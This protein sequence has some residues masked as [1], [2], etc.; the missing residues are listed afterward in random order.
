MSDES[1]SDSDGTSPRSVT[2]D[3]RQYLQLLTTGAV[4]GAVAVGIDTLVGDDGQ[5]SRPV[6]ITGNG[7][8]AYDVVV[9]EQGEVYEALDPTGDTLVSGSDGW[10]V[11]D[12][13]IDSVPE[14]G[15]IFVSGQYDGTSTIEIGKSIQMVGQQA[16]IDHRQLGD[17]VF[18][19]EGEELQRTTLAEATEHGD[20]TVTLEET[21]GIRK[22]DMV[23]LEEVDGDPVLGRDH[24]PGEPHSVLEVQDGTVGLEDTIVWRDGYPSGTLV[25]VV[26]PIEVHVSGFTMTA[27][28]KDE[29]YVGVTAHQCRDSSFSNLKIDKFGARGIMLEACANCRVRDCTVL[30]SADID[31]ADGYGVQIWAGCHDI[32]V[33]GCVAKECRHPLSVTA[34]GDR[35]VASRSITF[36]DCFVTANGSSALNCH[37]G[38]AHDVRFEGCVVHTWDDSGVSTGA[39]KTLVSDCEFRTN[40][41]NAIDTRDDGQEMILAVTDTDIFGAFSAVH[42]GREEKYTFEPLWEVVHLD[43]VR[44][45]GCNRYF[46]LDPGAVDRV[47]NLVI[48]SCYWDEVEEGGLRIENSIDGGVIEGN[49]FGGTRS[50]SH[51]R[52]YDDADVDV[53]DLQIAGNRFRQPNGTD[54]FIR[55]SRTRQCVV[56]GNKFEA[57]SDVNIYA[58][59]TGS[60]ANLITQN[61]YFAPQASADPVVEDSGSIARANSVYDTASERWL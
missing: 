56:S 4:G 19:F 57:G 5:D 9:E 14:G 34:G 29:S 2:T 51:I 53:T 58:D 15:S 24:P 38:S 44:A 59:E 48:S 3:R 31:A 41:N 54:T 39:Q 50:D 20:N 52:V 7:S 21:S 45:Y 18:R 10:T 35:T 37:G 13:A 33:D 49:D 40:G 12:N 43:E 25:Y 23:L 27:P 47:R 26:D 1:G 16:H 32:I 55:L 36:R 46:E 42:L 11:L 30:Q 17:P 6:V 8:A 22:G 61:T 28:A 60:T